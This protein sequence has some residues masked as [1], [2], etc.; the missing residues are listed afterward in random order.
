MSSS[1]ESRQ[2]W[3]RRAIVAAAG[4]LALG[5]ALGWAAAGWSPGR[6]SPVTSVTPAVPER[7]DAAAEARARARSALARG[8]AP[9][10]GDV[11][12]LAS[13][14]PPVPELE[15]LAAAGAFYE[16][17]AIRA[18]CASHPG[19]APLETLRALALL[20]SGDAALVPEARAILDAQRPREGLARELLADLE[21][22]GALAARV[23][24]LSEVEAVSEAELDK[25]REIATARE[26][27]E[28]LL[29][30]PRCAGTR[31]VRAVTTPL[32]GSARAVARG[33][34]FHKLGDEFAARVLLAALGRVPEEA[35]SP[36]LALELG[37]LRMAT[38]QV[39][40]ALRGLLLAAA[41]KTASQAHDVEQEGHDPVIAGSGYAL[42]ARYLGLALEAGSPGLG[43]RE[44]LARL[45][46]AARR[47]F[48]GAQAAEE[49]AWTLALDNDLER[50]RARI[51]IAG[52]ARAG[53]P[54]ER[55][56]R[57]EAALDDLRRALAL[58][59]QAA[60]ALENRR[61]ADSHATVD[62]LLELGRLSE[63]EALLSPLE[64][65]DPL[66]ADLLRLRHDLD[67][68]IALATRR[69][70]EGSED[71]SFIS[72]A[73]AVRALAYAE[74]GDLAGARADL[75]QLR[76]R[77]E[78]DALAR[79]QVAAVAR[80]LEEEAARRGGAR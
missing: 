57:F 71:E 5:T 8:Q 25:V 35:L 10:L 68:A 15:R 3:A 28:R 2:P 48:P 42:A 39:P 47:L 53:D 34:A 45:A 58:D 14:T 74:K 6:G 70:T 20:A 11:A 52:A 4:T 66:R 79:L 76:S 51:E 65:L 49:R 64:L 19:V 27:L 61:A 67:G 73:L 40:I 41:A 75:A 31:V 18:L 13:A 24:R 72:E 56:A 44:E 62:L 22:T 32:L 36:T 1:L 43:E 33:V 63:V 60:G 23:G 59:D 78:P 55:L 77:S 50:E 21:A 9:A 30:D 69:L 16:P 80:R 17:A 12:S 29:A 54:V 38:G 7:S 37:H 26:A 46:D